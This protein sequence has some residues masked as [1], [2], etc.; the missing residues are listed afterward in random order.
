MTTFSP[1]RPSKAPLMGRP[2]PE[3]EFSTIEMPSLTLDEMISKASLKSFWLGIS[4]RNPFDLLTRKIGAFS[5]ESMSGDKE[6][7]SLVFKPSGKEPC[8]FNFDFHGYTSKIYAQAVSN[9]G[10]EKNISYETVFHKIDKPDH[11][12]IR[13]ISGQ[14]KIICQQALSEDIEAFYRESKGDSAQAL[15]ISEIENFRSSLFK[16]TSLNLI[17]GGE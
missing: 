4:Y 9:E 5:L 17:I 14:A 7:F 2:S 13:A 3:S 11:V 16:V 10:E 1:P 12:L 8:Y 6:S 15:T